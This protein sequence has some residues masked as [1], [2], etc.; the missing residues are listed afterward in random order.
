MR[1]VSYP[2]PVVRTASGGGYRSRVM[3]KCGLG[4][5]AGLVKFAI[6]VGLVRAG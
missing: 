6:R 3:V 2:L 4:N 5:L 1:F